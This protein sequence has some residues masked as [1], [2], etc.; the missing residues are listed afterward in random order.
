MKPQRIIL[1]CF[2]FVTFLSFSQIPQL[3]VKHYH[4]EIFVSDKTDEIKVDELIEFAHVDKNKPIVLNLASHDRSHKGMQIESLKLN[5]Q[6]ATFN[7]QNDSIYIT[8]EGSQSKEQSLKLSFK[9]IPKDGLIIGKNKYGSRTFFGDN[10]PNRAQNWFACNDHL[11]DKATVEFI[12]HAPKHYKVVANGQLMSIKKS[13]ANKTY[14]Y[15]SS[16]SLPTKVMVI[17]VADMHIEEAGMID[18]K[19]VKSCVY[20]KHKKE[21][22]HDLEIAP[23]IL[24]FYIN[25]IAPYEYEKLDN[26]QSTTRFGGMENAACIFYDEDALDGTRT[27]EALIAHEIV[28]QWF[29]NSATEKDWCHL[30]LS[31]GFATYL[32]NV[33]FEQTKGVSAFRERL[34]KERK[35][36]ISFEKRYKS[37]VVDTAYNS[38]MDLLNPNSYQKGGWVLHMLRNELGDEDFH[39]TIRTYYQKYRLSNADTKDFQNVAEEVSDKDLQWFFDQWLFHRGHPKLNI[40]TEV[41]ENNLVMSISQRDLLFDIK[42]PIRVYFDNGTSLNELIGINDHQTRFK[43]MYKEQIERIEIDPDVQLLYEEVK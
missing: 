11:S 35:T 34:I 17:G 27:S 36:I 3:D 40:E 43:K 22:L 39:Q 14:H 8:S 21:A 25:Y 31:E 18:G 19:K 1:F 20:P 16:I 33:Y 23:S 26:V 42:L 12:V 9:G 10:W 13:K 2:V 37:P 4:I 15:N 7:H 6:K 28:H 24:E 41:H 30:W 5:G 29:G 38:L 32:T